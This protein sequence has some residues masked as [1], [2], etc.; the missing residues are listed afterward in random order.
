MS[1][2]ERG[3][4]TSMPAAAAASTATEAMHGRERALSMRAAH[5]PTA[6]PSTLPPLH[7]HPTNIHAT[8]STKIDSHLPTI[9]KD[10]SAVA[11]TDALPQ[12]N[13]DKGT[14]PTWRTNEDDASHS[15]H[16][17]S[18]THEPH[19]TMEQQ[20]LFQQLQQH[21][22]V[23]PTNLFAMQQQQQTT[24]QAAAG[25]T[26][27]DAHW[28]TTFPPPPPPSADSHGY[29]HTAQSHHADQ[30]PSLLTPPHYAAHPPSSST[31]AHTSSTPWLDSADLGQSFSPRL[32][33]SFNSPL[34]SES[35]RHLPTQSIAPIPPLRSAMLEPPNF[36]QFR[37]Y[38]SLNLPMQARTIEIQSMRGMTSMPASRRP[39]L[40]RAHGETDEEEPDDAMSQAS[41]RRGSLSF[42]FGSSSL[43]SRG[44]MS[45][46]TGPSLLS[47]G[48]TAPASG[49]SSGAT[50]PLRRFHFDFAPKVVATLVPRSSMTSLQI[51]GRNTEEERRRKQ[52]LEA[53]ARMA[54]T[55]QEEEEEDEMEETDE[56]MHDTHAAGTGGGGGKKRFLDGAAQTA[57]ARSKKLKTKKTRRALAVDTTANGPAATG[58]DAAAAGGGESTK[59]KKSA[60]PL[61]SLASTVSQAARMSR[62]PPGRR[63]SVPPSF[64]DELSSSAPTSASSRTID[65]DDSA[66]EES[67][68]GPRSPSPVKNK[69]C[70]LCKKMHAG[71][72]GGGR[73]CSA[74]C[75]RHFSIVQRW[76]KKQGRE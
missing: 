36:M 23:P 54:G 11:A 47:P 42:S 73:F 74:H 48:S 21:A 55:H 65:D 66:S 57:A 34:G 14:A 10:G 75:A 4:A 33:H 61:H 19:K 67:S 45:M 7:S 49:A 9:A 2:F 13:D 40:S 1:E 72:Y 37:Q 41:S 71:T 58:S 35:L 6:A 56:A 76:E 30:H 69:S 52:Q 15:A 29:Q 32:S 38:P 27:A 17:H 24:P 44:V 59:K 22:A 51:A 28:Q 63:R 25:T 39:S 70:E 18:G 3:R 60:S 64:F 12:S 46:P 53:S 26:N 31:A 43:M 62:R 16:A 50:S 5:A 20:V 8:H 68:A